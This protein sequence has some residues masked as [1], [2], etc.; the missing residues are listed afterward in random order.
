MD[1]AAGLVPQ[2]GDVVFFSAEEHVAVS[3]GRTWAGAPVDRFMSLW[4][5]N[6]RTMADIELDDFPPP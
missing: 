1:P 5:H 4:H 6:N 2:P 3:L